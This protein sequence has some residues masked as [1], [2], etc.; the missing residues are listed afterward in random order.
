MQQSHTC[1]L[2][3]WIYTFGIR[4]HKIISEEF[5]ISNENLVCPQGD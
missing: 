2:I 1:A 3:F 5:N 4:R